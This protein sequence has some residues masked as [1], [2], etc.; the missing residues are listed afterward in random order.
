M[1]DILQKIAIGV[2]TA[3]GISLVLWLAPRVVKQSRR[4]MTLLD[5]VAFIKKEVQSNHGESLKDHVT[6]ISESIAMVEA[7]QRGLVASMARAMF[8]TDSEFNWTEGN[9]SV[10]RLTGYGFTHLER[11]RWLA[12]VHDDDRSDVMHEVQCA[13]AD[14][15]AASIAFRFVPSSGDVV[16]VRMHADPVFSPVVENKVICW[17]GSLTKDGPDIDERRS[18]EERR[19]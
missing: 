7:R 13:V 14:K 5:D 9:V 11:R 8:E 16:P 19:H 18:I 6:K 1:D 3:A 17:T 15:R 2:G 4:V 10:E 12:R